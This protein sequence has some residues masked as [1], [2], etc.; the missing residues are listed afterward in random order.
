MKINVWLSADGGSDVYEDIEMPDD[1]TEEEIEKEARE[2]IFN[3]V[4]WGWCPVK[5]E[6]GE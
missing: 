1:A 3:H 5:E 2:A 6:D 4:S